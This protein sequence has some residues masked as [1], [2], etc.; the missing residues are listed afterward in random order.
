MLST[1]QGREGIAE[2]AEC[3]SKGLCSAFDLPLR[4]W[5]GP[6]GSM[7]D[8]EKR[9]DN[10]FNVDDIDEQAGSGDLG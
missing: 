7:E 10:G 6:G 1:L 8:E 2:R 4:S 3:V 5:A 9:E